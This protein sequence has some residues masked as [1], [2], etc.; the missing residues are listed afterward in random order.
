MGR[1]K[2]H[3][4]SSSIITCFGYVDGCYILKVFLCGKTFALYNANLSKVAT[5]ISTRG[6]KIF[7]ADVKIFF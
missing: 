5:G 2:W 1:F 7:S 4:I 6:L 3:E